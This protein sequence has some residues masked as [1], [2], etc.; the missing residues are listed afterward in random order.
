MIQET[1][2]TTLNLLPTLN[3]SRITTVH[4]L[5][6]KKIRTMQTLTMAT[7]LLLLRKTLKIVIIMVMATT[8]MIRLSITSH[9]LITVNTVK[10]RTLKN[11]S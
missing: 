5:T 10:I 8:T 9:L 4:G 2:T 1:H 3:P 6:Q 11:I 7:A